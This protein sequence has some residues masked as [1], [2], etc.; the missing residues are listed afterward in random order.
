MLKALP[1]RSL[2]PSKSL[3]AA[4][5]AALQ[6]TSRLTFPARSLPQKTLRSARTAPAPLS[7]PKHS[8]RPRMPSHAA[9]VRS[10]MVDVPKGR[11]GVQN[12]SLLP[13]PVAGPKRA[14]D[15]Y[16]IDHLDMWGHPKLLGNL[17]LYKWFG[18]VARKAGLYWPNKAELRAQ[19]KFIELCMQEV[20][21]ELVYPAYA[22]KAFHGYSSNFAADSVAQQATAMALVPAIM[23]KKDPIGAFAAR[24]DKL[25]QVSERLKARQYGATDTIHKVVDLCCGTG[26][27]T[28]VLARN[29]PD[30]Q[31]IGVDIS[32]L[33][34]AWAK[35][36]TEWPAD[37]FTVSQLEQ[38]CLRDNP[39]DLVDRLSWL[40]DNAEN[41]R[42]CAGQADRV[43]VPFAAHELPTEA[44]HNIMK[45]AY[46]ILKPGGW[47]AVVDTDQTQSNLHDGPE[48]ARQLA[49]L[50]A[51][52]PHLA[53]YLREDLG[54]LMADSGL[55]SIDNDPSI[56]G[57]TLVLGQK[58]L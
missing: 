34:L 47:L 23:T 20:R 37:M 45:E 16:N 13:A 8:E 41:T 33:M 32:W 57:C 4:Q 29:N 2:H 48:I 3:Q 52:E 28:R 38:I 18:G 55:T 31:V 15:V 9:R 35:A 58:P 22:L 36:T 39:Q 46:R 49:G 10:S 7:M 44:M 24:A 6:P 1:S 30:A 27:S 54:K 25:M 11:R 53:D 14:D 26:V 43:V 19:V 56:A 51:R 17:V 12:F 21:N 50:M 42:L 5:P 40:H